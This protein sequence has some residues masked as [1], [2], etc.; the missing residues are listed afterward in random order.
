[1]KSRKS[2]LPTPYELVDALQELFSD[3]RQTVAKPASELAYSSLDRKVI[4]ENKFSQLV[5]DGELDK[6]DEKELVT[7][8]IQLGLDSS[9]VGE[10][11]QRKFSEEFEPIK[12]RS[13]STHVITDE[14]LEEIDRLKKKYDIQLTLAGNAAV[15]R[16]IYLIES[17]RRLPE[18]IP[19]GLMLNSGEEA[20]Y[21]IPT[22]WRQINLQS[23]ELATLSQ[24]VLYVTSERLLFCGNLK[25]VSITL[26]N[27]LD[28]QFYSDALKVDKNTGK[29]EVFSMTSVEA[30]YILALIRALK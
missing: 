20:Y 17:K 27:I 15:F 26:K 9:Y 16:S 25:N 10:L 6:N 5:A 2:E 11:Q 23:A 18:P 12:R 13:E 1:M 29:P 14:D 7:L 24:G 3:F 28:C 30:R 19:T 21:S 8:A 4:L 22:S